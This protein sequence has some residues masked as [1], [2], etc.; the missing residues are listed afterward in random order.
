MIDPFIL[1]RIPHRPPFLWLDRVVAISGDT[2]RAEK[3]VD[4][5]LDV[6]R[7]HYPDYPLM[8][9][10]LLCEAVFQAGALLIGERMRGAAEEGDGVPVLTRILGAK[11]KREVRPGDTLEISASLVERMGPAWIMKGA[12]KVG[13]KTAV[14][15]EFA[16]ARK[17]G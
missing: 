1:E 17:G 5:D 2:I 8:P 9:G 14:Q 13:G 15:V 11:F 16:C 6:F 10:V 12:V 3:K 7:G 4:E